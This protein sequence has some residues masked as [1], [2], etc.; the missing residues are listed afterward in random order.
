MGFIEETGETG[1]LERVIP[2]EAPVKEPSPD[3][4]PA[5]APAAEPVP[6]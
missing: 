1:E 6:A 5:E 2:A 3:V 4:V